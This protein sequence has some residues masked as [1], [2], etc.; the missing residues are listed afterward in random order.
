MTMFASLFCYDIVVCHHT[1][2]K[3][4]VKAFIMLCYHCYERLMPLEGTGGLHADVVTTRLMKH[5]A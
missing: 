1:R 3:T 4:M 5:M 2:Q